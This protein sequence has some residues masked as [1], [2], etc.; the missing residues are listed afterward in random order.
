M[1]RLSSHLKRML[2]EALSPSVY[3][4]LRLLRDEWVE[5][6]SF[7][8]Y[9]QTGEDMILRHLYLGQETGF[10]VD[11]GAHHP[12]RFS[13]TH[14]FHRRGWRGINI[15]AMPGSMNAF[16]RE[17]PRDI[18]LE[19]GVGEREGAMTFHVFQEGAL[20][21]FDA[22]LAAQ[23]ARNGTR[24]LREIAVPVRPL[25]A[26]LRE[27]L[28]A[29]TRIDFLT[30]DVE[31]LDLEVLRSNDWE[32]HRP[33]CVVAEAEDL[34]LDA[35]AESALCG[36]MRERGYRLYAKTIASVFFLEGSDSG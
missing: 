17:R 32:T 23:R 8:T 1:S 27:H 18:N 35:P 11:V 10:Y 34:D 12:R 21:T 6:F 3:H 9:S 28:P 30:V 13:N 14:Y 19:L 22:E 15:D 20:N 26:I 29:N 33:R 4:R 36:F 16:R 31:G 25:A 24:V 5:G 7:R 2:G